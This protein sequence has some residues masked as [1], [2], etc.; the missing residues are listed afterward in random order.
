MT[1]TTPFTG[2]RVWDQLLDDYDHDQLADNW[3]KVDMH[4]H[5]PGRGVLLTTESI[6]P[7]SIAEIQIIDEQVSSSKIAPEAVTEPKIASGAITRRTIATG[8]IETANLGGEAVIASKIAAGAVETAKIAPE[9]VTEAKIPS[10]KAFIAPSNAYSART[11]VSISAKHAS[12]SSSRLV[13]ANIDFSLNATTSFGI[14]A[15]LHV[16]G[17]VVSE[18]FC[19]E[20]IQ[21]GVRMGTGFLLSPGQE[22]E[23]EPN[24]TEGGGAKIAGLNVSYKIL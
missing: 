22:W 1:A 4:D 7:N 15:R 13:W 8:A 18:F 24:G 11:S 3:F 6:A 16:G 14:A 21:G 2:L 19:N 9:A 12:P 10:G 5:T 17:V 23:L 20:S